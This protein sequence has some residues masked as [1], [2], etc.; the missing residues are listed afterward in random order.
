M[1]EITIVQNGFDALYMSYLYAK[2]KERFAFLPSSCD[3]KRQGDCSTLAFQTQKEYCPY[4][5][6][7]AEDN[8]ADVIAVGYK[9]LFFEKKIRVPLLS[10]TQ[11]RILITALVAADYKEDKSYVLQK[12]KGYNCYCLDGVYH[13]CLRGLQQ[14]WEGVA[15]YV[16]MDMGTPA[17][18]EFLRFLADDGTGKVFVKGNRVY[19]EEYRPL[20]KSVL[21]GQQSVVSEILL[22]GAE[23]VY[24]F[25]ETARETANFLKKYYREKAVFC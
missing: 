4:V 1:E 18:E 24:C 17:L 13:F 21:T 25:G 10:K 14:R 15:E 16:P 2:V 5:R 11:K 19:D 8:I 23:R 7:F 3:L 9:Y 12:L 20:S 22:C 6:R